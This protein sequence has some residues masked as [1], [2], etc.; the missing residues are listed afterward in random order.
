MRIIFMGTPE[1]AVA[2]LDAMVKASLN[3]VAV[4]TSPDTF[5]GRGGKQRIE[6]PVKKYAHEAQL[7]LLQPL[8]LKD[9]KFLET[10]RS[11]RADLQIVVAF[12]MLP[13]VV[14]HMPPLGTFNLHGSLLPK[15]RGAAPIQH[16]L[17]Q[18]ESETG[19][20]FF[21]LKHEIDTGDVLLERSIPIYPDDTFGVL[22]DRMKD[23][24]AAV[25][26]E[27]IERIASGTAVYS[28]QNNQ[29][30]TLAPKINLAFCHIR[31]DQD[32]L[33][34]Y[35]FIRGL[36]PYP[37]AYFKI[38]DS[39]VKVVSATWSRENHQKSPGTIRTT[40]KSM[41]I[42]ALNGWID[43]QE[44]KPEGKKAMSI[45]DFLNGIKSLPSRV[46]PVR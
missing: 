41:S 28:P 30:A 37:C 45:Q 46:D 3:I 40:K 27:G 17:I 24:A 33:Q 1:F 42:S 13:E 36:S 25:V 5:G 35:N 23:V 16:A 29:E 22:H 12:R 20:T 6:S 10:L 2:T 4:I 26:V 38:E 34:V 43:I 39:I 44:L 31:F 19:V 15:Y 32:V 8:R 11:F 7:P 21:K 18:G 14:W 9:P